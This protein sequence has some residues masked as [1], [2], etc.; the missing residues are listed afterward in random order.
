[1][2]KEILENYIKAVVSAP[3]DDITLLSKDFEYVE[4]VKND[5]TLKE[6][7]K[8]EYAYFLEEGFLRTYVKN[9]HGDEVTTNIYSAPHFINDFLS[10]FRQAPTKENFQAITNCRMW[11]INYADAQSSYNRLDEFRILGRNLLVLSHSSLGNRMISMVA[12]SAEIRY[13]KLLKHHPNLI[14]NVPL[15]II[16]SYLGITDTSLS[17]IRKEISR[18]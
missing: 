17:R 5:F 13:T 6:G 7:E 11:R 14:Q 16:A 10:F 8:S 2:N 15:K 9:I 3:I 1:M 12:D 18:K 4:I